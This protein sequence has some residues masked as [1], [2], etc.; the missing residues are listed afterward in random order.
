MDIF[1][2]LIAGMI[3]MAALRRVVRLVLTEPPAERPQLPES[4]ARDGEG[5]VISSETDARM[6][7]AFNGLNSNLSFLGGQTSW[8]LGPP[9]PVAELEED[10]SHIQA[11]TAEELA[12]MEQLKPY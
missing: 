4:F 1:V 3:L 9:P 11:L 6:R 2:L 7:Q 10:G 5:H 8:D 12:A